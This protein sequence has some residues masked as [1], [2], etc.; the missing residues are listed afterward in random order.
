M[1]RWRDCNPRPSVFWVGLL[2]LQT[3]HKH[4]CYSRFNWSFPKPA[5]RPPEFST[6]WLLF[7]PKYC[8]YVVFKKT[9]KCSQMAESQNR[10]LLKPAKFWNRPE[11]AASSWTVQT[12]KGLRLHA[13]LL[14]PFEFFSHPSYSFFVPVH[15][16]SEHVPSTCFENIVLI[17][18]NFSSFMHPVTLPAYSTMNRNKKYMNW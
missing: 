5:P 2:L 10:M 6:F 17:S 9:L 14:K 13:R 1:H 3:V 12:R 16:L 15:I 11:K 18:V 7:L 4:L 8:L